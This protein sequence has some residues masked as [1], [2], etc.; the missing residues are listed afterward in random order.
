MDKRRVDII[1]KGMLENKKEQEGTAKESNYYIINLLDRR[2][3]KGNK[4]T[5]KLCI[6]C[7]EIVYKERDGG[8]GYYFYQLNG[9]WIRKCVSM[10]A[11]K[12]LMMYYSHSDYIQH[13][14]YDKRVDL[15]DH[16]TAVRFIHGIRQQ[17]PTKVSIRR[18][19]GV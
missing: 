17:S 9:G 13:V 8:V 19:N 7:E 16:R 11:A 12:R 15:S 1:C 10:V 5:C 4:W 18:C 3:I 14:F 2:S 6:I